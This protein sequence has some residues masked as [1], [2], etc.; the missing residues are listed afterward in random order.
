MTVSASA[1]VQNGAS[2]CSVASRQKRLRVVPDLGQHGAIGARRLVAPLGAGEDRGHEDQRRRPGHPRLVRHAG[3]EGAR[4]Q[5]AAHAGRGDARRRRSDR[6]PAR[7]PATRRDRDVGLDRMPRAARR[8][9]LQ[10]H[11]P[12]AVD[13]DPGLH[14]PRQAEQRRQRLERQRAASEPAPRTPRPQRLR[15]RRVDRRRRQHADVGRRRLDAGR[16][17][18]RRRR[19][20]GAAPQRGVGDAA[21]TEANVAGGVVEETG[22]RV[23]R[24]PRCAAASRGSGRR[25]RE[26]S[27]SP[28]RTSARSSGCRVARDAPGSADGQ[29][30]DRPP[31]RGGVE[32]GDDGAAPRPSAC[33]GRTGAAPGRRAASR[34]RRAAIDDSA[35]PLAATALR[36]EPDASYAVGGSP[37]LE[38]SEA[39]RSGT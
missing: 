16:D 30:V 7:T 12:E 22:G 15:Q 24:A 38:S 28:R 23:P 13:L 33:R 8:R 26:T 18:H 39:S 31:H 32:N 36:T 3:G 20:A 19:L 4:R 35:P 2:P 5:P 34:R 10:R 37:A 6:C 21:R 11:P 25:R 9:R 17:G 14:A 1:I 29:I 27:R